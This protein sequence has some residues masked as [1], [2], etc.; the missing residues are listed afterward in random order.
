MAQFVSH[1]FA[2]AIEA[3]L[4]DGG[5]SSDDLVEAVVA[6]APVW[7]HRRDVDR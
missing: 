1:G 6:C 2:G 5:L 7:W 4:A 3:W